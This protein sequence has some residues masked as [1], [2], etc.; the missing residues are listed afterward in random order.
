MTIL[1]SYTKETIILL[2]S[3]YDLRTDCSVL[4]RNNWCERRAGLM[5][6]VCG[7][8]C[9]LCGMKVAEKNKPGKVT[10]PVY[11]RSQV[12]VTITTVIN[13]SLV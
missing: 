11:L 12:N 8:T 13:P 5:K 6:N 4:K 2:A 1:R 9:N 3:C 7:K 10:Y